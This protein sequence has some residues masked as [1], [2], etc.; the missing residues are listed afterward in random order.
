M[1]WAG[2]RRLA[3]ITAKDLEFGFLAAWEDEFRRR[4]KREPSSNS[5][6]TAIQALS[7]F[8][9]FLERFDFLVDDEGARLGTRRGC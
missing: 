7:S 8:Y 2:E 1:E 6:R 3:E 5:M 4:N 9:N